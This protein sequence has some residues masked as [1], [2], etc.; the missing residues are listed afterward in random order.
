VNYLHWLA[1]DDTRLTAVG[2]WL[3]ATS[4]DEL[5]Q[6][7][8]VLLGDMSLVGPRPQVRTDANLYTAAEQEMLQVRPGITDLASIVF[9]DEGDILEGSD[10]P[11]LLYN[12]IIR[13]WKSR[14]ALLYVKRRS[15]SADL[16]IILLTALG[17]VDRE[18]ALEGVAAIL[19]DWDADELLCA[20][21]RRTEPLRPFPPPGSSAVV[22]QYPALSV[23]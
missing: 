12:Q 7:F 9:A 21:A 3:R 14:L 5:P 16:H 1:S 13:P 11:D 17:A 15:F 18:L 8:N 22:D 20:I 19:E 2:R 6:L 10:H 23:T 4:L